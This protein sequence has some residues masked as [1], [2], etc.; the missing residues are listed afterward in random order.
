[1]N[2]RS[3]ALLM[4]REN[5]RPAAFDLEGGKM[6][7]CL[8]LAPSSGGWSVYFYERGKR[9][10]TRFFETEDEAC[11]FMATELLRDPSTRQRSGQ[12]P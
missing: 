8:S 5:I 2:R 6:D 3:L 10:F 1:M 12:S 7:E 4:A 11:D 9:T